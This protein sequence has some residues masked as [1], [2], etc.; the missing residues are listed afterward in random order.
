MKHR[1]F[2]SFQEETNFWQKDDLLWNMLK[3]QSFHQSTAKVWTFLGMVLNIGIQH[4]SESYKCHKLLPQ[5]LSSAI[6][7]PIAPQATH[8]KGTSAPTS[9][10]WSSWR[11]S[12]SKVR[13]QRRASASA[14]GKEIWGIFQRIY[15]HVTMCACV[16][17]NPLWRS[18]SNTTEITS[19][20]LWIPL[21]FTN[22]TSCHP[23][24]SPVAGQV[25]A[26]SQLLSLTYEQGPD[27][28]GLDSRG[29]V[30]K[31]F[32][33]DTPFLR[34]AKQILVINRQTLKLDRQI[35]SRTPFFQGAGRNAT[36]INSKICLFCLCLPWTRILRS[37][38]C[39][40]GDV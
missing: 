37:L 17:L 3:R 36:E 2:G 35:L 7:P 14:C 15:Q 30:F 4:I 40:G 38:W 1:V 22:L 16:K 18:L 5:H 33:I 9:V 34:R 32:R 8:E 27:S 29:L 25:N 31:A 24:A 10:I 19:D 13:L 12:S 28:K 23:L 26:L 21:V 6:Q 39:L 20:T 11:H